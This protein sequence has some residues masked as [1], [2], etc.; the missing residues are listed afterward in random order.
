MSQDFEL[1][2]PKRSGDNVILGGDWK[3][4]YL[5]VMSRVYILSRAD[6][7]ELCVCDEPLVERTKQELRDI[8]DFSSL[9][10]E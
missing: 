3:L 10:K 4:S 1:E 2:A 6:E 5:R 9:L 8:L 7:D